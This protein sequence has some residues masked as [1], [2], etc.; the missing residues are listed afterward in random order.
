MRIL[1]WITCLG[2]L[3]PSCSGTPRRNASFAIQ[4]LG[5]VPRDKIETVQNRIAETYKMRGT[6]LPEVRAPSSAY[7]RER[8][9]YDADDLLSFLDD[10][11]DERFT[12][13]LGVIVS[14]IGVDRDGERASGIMGIADLNDRTAVVS[15][16]RLSYGGADAALQTERLVRVAT[17]ETG[18]LLGLP[19]C[20]H[21]RCLMQDARGAVATIDASTGRLCFRCLLRL[22]TKRLSAVG[23]KKTETL[24]L[25]RKQSFSP[26]GARHQSPGQVHEVNAAL[27]Q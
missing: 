5:H 12:K 18:H 25:I 20:T 27:G 16:H 26:D 19:H 3:L 23:T 1:F 14:D 17:H 9:R 21:S 10:Q 22:K 15:L 4:P 2:F 13:V 7:V 24:G 8:D 6:I 11:T